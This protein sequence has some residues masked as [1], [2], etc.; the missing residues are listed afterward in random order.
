MLCNSFFSMLLGC[1]ATLGHP[2]HFKER[3]TYTMGLEFLIDER[4]GEAG[5]IW[6]ISADHVDAYESYLR[7]LF[8]LGMASRLAVRGYVI[9]ICLGSLSTTGSNRIGSSTTKELMSD[10]SLVLGGFLVLD[11]VAINTTQ[12]HIAKGKLT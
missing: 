4:T 11:P 3:L 10:V 12:N 5:T 1:T 7:E 2:A 8:G 6:I 9:L